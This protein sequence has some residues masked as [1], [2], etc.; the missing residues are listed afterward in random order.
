MKKRCRIDTSEVARAKFGTT[1]SFAVWMPA[2]GEKGVGIRPEIP[3]DWLQSN[4]HNLPFLQTVGGKRRTRVPQRQ[5]KE[6]GGENGLKRPALGRQMSYLT[7]GA[8]DTQ[9]LAG[10][11]FICFLG[12]DIVGWFA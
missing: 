12:A 3:F 8:K 2:G 7:W 5:N 11:I 4:L 6:C 9:F 1:W 10:S